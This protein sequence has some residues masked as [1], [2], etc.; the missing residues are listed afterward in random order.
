MC[1]ILV[2]V[3]AGQKVGSLA[4]EKGYSKTLFTLLFVG[5]WFVGEIMGAII[6]SV[7]GGSLPAIYG[8]ALLLAILGGLF[9]FIVTLVLPD[10][11]DDR[12]DS[13]GRPLVRGRSR[14]PGAGR[15][16]RPPSDDSYREKFRPR[17]CLEEEVDELEIIED[18]EGITE[19]DEVRKVPPKRIPPRPPPRK[20][21]APP[22]R[23]R[24]PEL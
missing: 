7:I 11:R 14:R 18:D 24:P 17:R 6:G 3:F 10:G 2:I 9:A 8:T 15:K 23:R 13:L 19:A 1:E 4:E 5:C 21:N 12:F 16:R 22:P 20:P